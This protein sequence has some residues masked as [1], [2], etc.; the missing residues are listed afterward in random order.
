MGKFPAKLIIRW[1]DNFGEKLCRGTA[2][3]PFQKMAC[4]LEKKHWDLFSNIFGHTDYVNK[5]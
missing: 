2:W 5:F 4:F 1:Y 3:L